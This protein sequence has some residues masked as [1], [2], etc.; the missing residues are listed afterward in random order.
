L[1]IL[2]G[3]QGRDEEALALFRRTGT[4]AQAQSNM[5]F[6]YTQ[7]GQLAAAMDAYNRALT[8]DNSLRPAADALVQ[9]AKYQPQGTDTT[10]G[11]SDSGSPVATAKH[12]VCLL[13]RKHDASGAKDEGVEVVH[14]RPAVAYQA[15]AAFRAEVAADAPPKAHAA[16][17]VQ[18]PAD[19][20]LSPPTPSA[21]PTGV[22]S[23]AGPATFGRCRSAIEQLPTAMPSP[24]SVPP[25]SGGGWPPTAGMGFAPPTFGFESNP[26][27]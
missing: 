13:E 23:S 10:E 20:F 22:P 25:T 7:R 8:L 14:V 2:L 16:E 19:A 26:S 17:P 27:P 9:L 1:A 3:E 11:L 12:V 18:P 6:I 5:A 21:W 15:D 4:E 24:A